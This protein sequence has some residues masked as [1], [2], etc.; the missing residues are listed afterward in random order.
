M[1]IGYIKLH[2]KL[3]SWEWY[4]D[5]NTFRLFLHLLMKANHKDNKWQGQIIKRGQLVTGRKSLSAELKISERSIRTAFN[6]LIKTKEVTSKATNR[7]TLVTLVN[8]DSYQSD[9]SKVT[10]EL[11]SIDQLLT[12]NKNV[13]NVK[14]INILLGGVKKFN[15][16]W[17]DYVN[18]RT[19]IKKPLTIQSANMALKTLA[20]I[21]IENGNPIDSINNSIAQG[22]SGLFKPKKQQ[23]TIKTT[24]LDINST[25]WS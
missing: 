12:T 4:Q 3:M 11:P 23:P 15:E 14:N 6:R 7:Y 20:E 21:Y 24:E 18:H 13:K 17:L 8:Y 25:G 10:N 2:R 19:L 16:S 5:A 1:S 9:K 22:W